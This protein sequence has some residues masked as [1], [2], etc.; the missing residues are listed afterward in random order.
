MNDIQEESIKRARYVAKMRGWIRRK[1]K[2]RYIDICNKC[3]RSK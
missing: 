2:G 1:V 3:K